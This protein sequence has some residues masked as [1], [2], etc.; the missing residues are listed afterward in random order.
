M[1]I[2]FVS[3]T[4]NGAFSPD[5][6]HNFLEALQQHRPTLRAGA[7]RVRWDMYILLKAVCYTDPP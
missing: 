5:F 2:N 1:L 6:R 3:E 4:S 7:V